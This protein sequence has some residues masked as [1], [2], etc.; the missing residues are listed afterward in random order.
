MAVITATLSY[1]ID[2]INVFVVGK[3]TKT[4]TPK[5]RIQH[6]YCYNLS[7]I[8]KAEITTRF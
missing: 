4:I 6:G 2:I 3:K 5:V 7:M 8:M 1:H